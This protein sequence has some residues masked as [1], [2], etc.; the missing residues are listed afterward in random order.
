[1]KEKNLDLEATDVA[2]ITE[3]CNRAV[4][5]NGLIPHPL[6][7]KMKQTKVVVLFDSNDF[8]FESVMAYNQKM[9]E[10]YGAALVQS[11]LCNFSKGSLSK[12]RV[13]RNAL[14]YKTIYGFTPNEKVTDCRNKS[15]KG[16][17]AW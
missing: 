7:G 2:T 11:V 16:G 6:T 3:D 5:V 10:V 17:A 8:E 1:M 13:K 15:T 14:L 12:H 4:I 9:M